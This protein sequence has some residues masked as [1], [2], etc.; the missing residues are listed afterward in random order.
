MSD[1]YRSIL[2]AE[3]EKTAGIRGKLI[4]KLYKKTAANTTPGRHHALTPYDDLGKW[5]GMKGKEKKKVTKAWRAAMG[6]ATDPESNKLRQR[7]RHQ[8]GEKGMAK[9]QKKRVKDAK[10]RGARGAKILG[11]ERKHVPYAAGAALAGTALAG[12]AIGSAIG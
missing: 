5:G 4:K 10:K 6:G 12:T 2:N 9:W 7:I 1:I 11:L 3:I 8:L